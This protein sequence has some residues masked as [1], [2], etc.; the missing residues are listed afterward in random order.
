[1][2]SRRFLTAA[3]HQTLLRSVL[4]PTSAGASDSAHR[5][6]ESPLQL[7]SPQDFRARAEHMRLLRKCTSLTRQTVLCAPIGR[8]ISR[9]D[10]IFVWAPLPASNARDARG[11][12]SG[13]NL[14]PVGPL[15]S[16]LQGTGAHPSSWGGHSAP[17][18]RPRRMPFVEESVQ[19]MYVVELV[20]AGYQAADNH[21]KLCAEVLRA[22][23]D[24]CV[25][26]M[27]S[28]ARI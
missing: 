5:H 22:R 4:V 6:R 18:S 23:V 3:H 10:M 2:L 19:G 17:S 14:A 8:G 15:S 16:F 13:A 28:P 7:R 1:M 20:V 25:F 27:A 9:A 21:P 12:I 11:S 24:Q 26:P